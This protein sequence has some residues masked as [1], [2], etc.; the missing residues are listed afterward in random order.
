MRPP[1]PTPRT[2]NT[3]INNPIIAIATGIFCG[4]SECAG[5]EALSR[6][7]AGAGTL[8]KRRGIV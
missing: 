1:P 5:H 3:R 8:A 6:W 7:D 2:R 4:R